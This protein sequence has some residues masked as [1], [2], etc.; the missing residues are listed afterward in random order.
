M[1]V[2]LER[3]TRMFIDMQIVEVGDMKSG[4][5]FLGLP[6]LLYKNDPNWISPLRNDVAAV[7]DPG[8]NIFFQHGICKRWVLY[9]RMEKPIGRIAAFI[10]HAK[11]RQQPH[12]SGGIGFF[13]CINDKEAAFLLFDTAKHWLERQGMTAM[14]GPINFGEN[15]RFWGLLVEGFRPAS[16]GMNYNPRYYEKLF[17]AYGFEKLYDQFTNVLDPN[18]PLPERFRKIADWVMEKPGYTFRHFTKKNKE[19]FFRDLQEVYNDAW[20]GFENFTPLK[21]E[22]IRESFRQMKPILDEKL[23]WFAYFDQEP[24]AFIVCLPDANQILRHVHGKMNLF[25]KLKFLWYRHTSTVD[26]IRIIIMGAKKK[27]QNHGMESAFIRCLQKEVLPRNTIKD[28]ELAW[29]GDF[30]S[31]MIALHKA[32]GAKLEK[33]HRTYRYVFPDTLAETQRTGMKIGASS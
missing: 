28:V 31:K 16:L 20:E 14:E 21:I 24:I 8:R 18:I 22:T 25:G 2:A 1:V 17:T 12:P 23:I 4:E 3:I 32:T 26:R 10:N 29:V 27:F 13:E 19:Q 15:D 11:A 30:N 7:F 5:E 33:V 6:Q 9:N